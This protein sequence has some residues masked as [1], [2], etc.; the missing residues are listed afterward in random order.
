MQR[1]WTPETATP[2]TLARQRRGPPFRVAVQVAQDDPHMTN[3]A[4]ALTLF[5]SDM[6]CAPLRDAAGVRGP[7]GAVA[8]G[9]VPGRQSRPVPLVT[10]LRSSSRSPLTGAPPALLVSRF[11]SVHKQARRGCFSCSWPCLDEACLPVGGGTSGHAR[12]ARLA[13]PRASSPSPTGLSGPVGRAVR[14]RLRDRPPCL[15]FRISGENA[16]A[17]ELRGVR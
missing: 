17:L 14:G 3:L 5:N 1:F 4:L 11:V 13:P 8:S 9:G 15:L 2:L 12:G 7:A 10:A 6:A 16:E